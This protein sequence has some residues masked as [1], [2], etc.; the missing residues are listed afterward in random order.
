[1]KLTEKSLK[2]EIQIRREML[3]KEE[4]GRHGRELGI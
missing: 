2:M 4:T 1:M 3:E